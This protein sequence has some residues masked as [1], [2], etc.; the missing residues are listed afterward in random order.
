MSTICP[1]KLRAPLRIRITIVRMICRSASSDNDRDISFLRQ[2]SSVP[3]QCDR[4]DCRQDCRIADMGAT[5]CRVQWEPERGFESSSPLHIQICFGNTE[6]SGIR[7]LQ[8]YTV[9]L[10]PALTDAGYQPCVFQFPQ[11]GLDC[12][13]APIKIIR[14]LLDRI[15]HIY[16]SILRLPTVF[17]GKHGAVQK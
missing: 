6:G 16:I 3:P 1:K 17:L 13:L 2:H 11:S 8:E 7:D 15:N 5:Q 12:P 9:C 14:H 4:S 10:I